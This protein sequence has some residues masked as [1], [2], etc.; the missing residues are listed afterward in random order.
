MYQGFELK[1]YID[2]NEEPS[3]YSLLP[4]SLITAAQTR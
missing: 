1:L 2:S 4:L 3:H